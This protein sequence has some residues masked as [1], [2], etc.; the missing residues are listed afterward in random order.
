MY[1]I[2]YDELSISDIHLYTEFILWL[3]MFIIVIFLCQIFICYIKEY[4]HISF[5][6]SI[7]IS[8]I[9]MGMLYIIYCL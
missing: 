6:E 1:T 3:G 5:Q 7:K 8:I 2:M 9:I 4:N